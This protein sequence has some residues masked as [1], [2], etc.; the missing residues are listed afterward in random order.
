MQQALVQEEILASLTETER[1]IVVAY[2]KQRGKARDLAHALGVSERTVYK[3][4]Y[5]YRK[6]ARERGVDPSAFYLRGSFGYQ[7]DN[8]RDE[9]QRPLLNFEGIKQE[10][11][12]ELVPVIEEAVRQ[13]VKQSL[14][15]LLSGQ[16]GRAAA[17][18]PSASNHLK[19]DSDQIAR[20]ILTIEKLNENLVKF[21]QA[22]T[23][24]YSTG[25]PRVQQHSWQNR[26]HEDS[27]PSFVVGN[28]WLE[29]LSQRY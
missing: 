4:L 19:S 5:K 15:E 21:G 6:L 11:I 25:T 13:A 14:E 2:L 9:L 3:A 8:G 27:L 23:N 10:I 16:R 22:I 26:A 7:P 18:S 1:R 20:L 12:A 29:V 24:L 28:P 17:A